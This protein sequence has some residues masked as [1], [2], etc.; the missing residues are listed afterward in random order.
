MLPLERRS[1]V[2]TV[3]CLSA[4]LASSLPVMLTAQLAVHAKG[5]SS[6]DEN[7]D[8]SVS[9]PNSGTGSSGIGGMMAFAFTKDK[10]SANT[11]ILDLKI[12]KQSPHIPAGSGTSSPSGLLIGNGSNYT[13]EVK[14]LHYNPIES[15]FGDG[16]GAKNSG[17]RVKVTENSEFRIGSKPTIGNSVLASSGER[18]SSSTCVG[19]KPGV[20]GLLD[21]QASAVH[22]ILASTV[23]CVDMPE[24]VAQSFYDLFNSRKSSND[25]NPP[26]VVLRF[27]NDTTTAGID[28]QVEIVAGL[29]RGRA[30]NPA[31]AAPGPL[32]ILGAATAFGFSRKLRRRIAATGRGTAF[33]A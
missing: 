20:N 31:D 16:S 1:Q 33:S 30:Q 13:P 3:G 9:V 12:T 22:F 4:L 15:G 32:P 24:E 25:P 10:K 8:S 19:G 11:Y 14:L 7:F 28:G 17:R 2:L 29:P 21:G 26:Q 23:S 6:L 27:Q 18:D 5:F